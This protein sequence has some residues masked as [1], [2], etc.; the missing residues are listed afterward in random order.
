MTKLVPLALLALATTVCAAAQQAQ[1]SQSIT[2]AA[3]TQQA[4]EQ[5]SP[6]RKVWTNDDFPDQPAAATPATGDTTAPAS[7]TA[8]AS[9]ATASTATDDAKKSADD[10]SKSAKADADDQEKL[11]AEW[12]SK[13]DT[14]KAKIADLQR[15][16]DLTDREF[17]LA[18]TTY[19]ADA[20]NRLRDPKDFHDKETA[21]RDKLGTLK[22]QIADEQAKLAELQDQA[23]K[24]GASKAYD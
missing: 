13:L 9:T 3:R 5:A 18:S 6:G 16:F 23:H 2:D 21:F 15:E 8:P 11:N 17:K 19:Y 22:Q 7:S 1:S 14:E 10:K 20:G 4:K 24:A 12:K